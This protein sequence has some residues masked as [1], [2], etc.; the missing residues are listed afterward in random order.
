MT[1]ISQSSEPLTNVIIGPSLLGS[2]L[3]ITILGY[4]PTV[5]GSGVALVALIFYMIQIRESKSYVSWQGAK[6][7]KKHAKELAK[8]KAK[9]KVVIAKIEA[10]EKVRDEWLA[11]KELLEREREKA[12]SLVT[13]N[14]ILDKAHTAITQAKKDL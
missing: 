11:A 7:I 2:T 6:A 14:D 10:I 5:I 13:E 8:L 1:M 12:A 4:L 9:E 3:A